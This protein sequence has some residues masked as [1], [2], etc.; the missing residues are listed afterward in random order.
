MPRANS[1]ILQ[2][3]RL[4]HVLQ[5]SMPAKSVPTDEELHVIGYLKHYYG[6]NTVKLLIFV[7]LCL[8]FF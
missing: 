8:N 2:Q 1:N 6:M 5:T 3:K 4:K 7:F